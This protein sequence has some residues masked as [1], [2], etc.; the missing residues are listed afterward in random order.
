MSAQDSKNKKS[1]KKKQRRT[2][3]FWLIVLILSILAFSGSFWFFY[4]LTSKIN[5]RSFP[6]TDTP[7]LMITPTPDVSLEG[8]GT[9]MVGNNTPLD[10]PNAK[11]S[12]QPV[13][14]STATPAPT[15]TPTPQATPEP[16]ATPTPTP[17][18]TRTP[19]PT[20]TPK[21]SATATPVQKSVF[22]VQVGSYPGRDAAQQTASELS[23]KGYSTL[24][25]EDGG[26]FRVQLGSYDSQESAL[27]LAEEVTQQG[28]EVVVRKSNR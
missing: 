9:Y 12:D 4:M 11:S 18:P 14:V 19:V 13:A 27:S 28:Y 2:D 23:E 1:K 8:S 24:I 26:R 5:T 20:P 10:D 3:P 6:T 15:A 7:K 16:T 17:Q 22:V 25:I 21:P